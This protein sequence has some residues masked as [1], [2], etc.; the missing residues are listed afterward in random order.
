MQK[1]KKKKQHSDPEA[2]TIL[3]TDETCMEQKGGSSMQSRRVD[4]KSARRSWAQLVDMEA[5]RLPQELDAMSGNCV[6]IGTP[7]LPGEKE[8]M[9]QNLQWEQTTNQGTPNVDDVQQTMMVDIAISDRDLVERSQ[10]TDVTK[11]Q[12]ITGK[13]VRQ[14]TS[15]QP[16]QQPYASRKTGLQVADETARRSKEED[17]SRE[18]VLD[19]LMDPAWKSKGQRTRGSESRTPKKLKQTEQGRRP[20][21]RSRSIRLMNQ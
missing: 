4:M 13:D 1:E 8:M 19:E 7:S 12:T 20:R 14:Q 18:E 5:L 6:A 3:M 9:V 2:G 21:S 15:E 10:I 17:L 11:A 16:V